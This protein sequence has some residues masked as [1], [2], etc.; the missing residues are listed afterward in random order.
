MIVISKEIDTF[1]LKKGYLSED[2]KC[3]KECSNKCRFKIAHMPKELSQMTTQDFDSLEYKHCSKRTVL[4]TLGWQS[5]WLGIGR[6]AGHASTLRQNNEYSV[7]FE[8]NI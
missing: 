4:N 3:I 2:L 8:L 6:T 5:F 7:S 1:L